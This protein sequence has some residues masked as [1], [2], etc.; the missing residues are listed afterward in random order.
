MINENTKTNRDSQLSSKLKIQELV[1][2]NYT[3]KKTENIES[4]TRND[5]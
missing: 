3:L 2:D 1:L 4:K 5:D